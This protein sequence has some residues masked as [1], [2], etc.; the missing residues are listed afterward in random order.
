MR[1][2][3]PSTNLALENLLVRDEPFPAFPVKIF[4]FDGCCPFGDVKTF[5]ERGRWVNL[6]PFRPSSTVVKGL[7]EQA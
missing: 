6:R 2:Y 5:D 1:Y 7:E 4:V 3:T